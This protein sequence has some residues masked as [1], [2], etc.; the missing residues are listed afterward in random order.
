MNNR[1]NPMW[2]AGLGSPNKSGRPKG[3]KRTAK[4]NLERLAN[5]ILTVKEV[6]S[7]YD[8]MKAGSER[9]Q[10]QKELMAYLIP[11]PTADSMSQEELEALHDKLETKIKGDVAQAKKAI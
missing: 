6:K 11:K 4:R 2:V 8:H 10:M 5:L 3:S 7:N 1:G 9:W